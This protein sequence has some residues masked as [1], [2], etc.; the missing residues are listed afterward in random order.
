LIE[1]GT[2]GRPFRLLHDQDGKAVLDGKS[3]SAALADE[4]FPFEGEPGVARVHGA[5]KDF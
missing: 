2:T 3:E 1:A 5:A 4:P